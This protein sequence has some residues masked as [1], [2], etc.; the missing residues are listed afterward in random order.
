MCVHTQSVHEPINISLPTGGPCIHTLYLHT[1]AFICQHNMFTYFSSYHNFLSLGL[2]GL[3]TWEARADIWAR[4][5]ATWLRCTYRSRESCLG[6]SLK[7]YKNCMKR[8]FFWRVLILVSVC[9]CV[10]ACACACLFL[11]VCIRLSSRGQ[12]E[13]CRA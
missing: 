1:A 6:F 5:K 8:F 3:R 13:A 2:W 11:S 9:V 12:T 10:C 4:R 7:S